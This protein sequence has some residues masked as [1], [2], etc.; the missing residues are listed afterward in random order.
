MRYLIAGAGAIGAYIG[1]RMAA[2]GEDVTLFARGA[3]LEAM[4]ARGVR[5]QSPDGEFHAQ[6]K[7][8]G[9]LEAAGPVD[10]VILG[11]KAHGLTELA[12]KLK[13]LLSGDTVVVSTQ[14]GVPWWY[15]DGLERVDPGCVIA[16]AIEPERVLGSIVYFSTDVPEPGLIRHTEGN[17]ISLGEPDGTRSDRGREIGDALNRAGFRCR[18]TSHIR[19][20][21]W[22]KILG[23]VAFNPISALTRATL[24]QMTADPEISNLVRSIMTEAEAVATALGMELPVSIEQRIA[25]AAK[26][27]DHKTSMLQDLELGRP[28]ELEA[29]VGAVVEL[30]ERV[31]VPMPCTRAVYG[32]ARLLDQITRVARHS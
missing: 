22:V 15:F 28:L 8:I 24:A 31:G 3:H 18:V 27:G 21:I 19:Q 2:A 1:A 10:V 14:N 9:K 5:V 20:E 17:R 29:I 16:R 26:V 25:G 4:L 13:P 7:I 12:P 6:P 32:C 30:G 23:N 11:V